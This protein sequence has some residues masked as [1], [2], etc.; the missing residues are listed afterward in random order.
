MSA[1]EP[2][3]ESARSQR[4]TAPTLTPPAVPKS[5]A[6]TR[7]PFGITVSARTLSLTPVPNTFHS[8]PFHRAI[9]FAY[10]FTVLS[11]SPPTTRSPLGMTTIAHTILFMPVFMAD[12]PVPLQRRTVVTPSAVLK[13]PPTIRSPLGITASDV[14]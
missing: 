5:P 7:S 6:A 12:H 2:P 8:V 13:M 11:K 9:W 10:P 4:A 3:A 14:T 1:S